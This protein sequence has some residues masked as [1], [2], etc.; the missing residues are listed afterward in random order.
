MQ[1]FTDLEF[2]GI[3]FVYGYCNDIPKAAVREYRRLFSQR[4]VP[5]YKTF[6]TTNRYLQKLDSFCHC[7]GQGRPIVINTKPEPSYLSMCL[8]FKHFENSIPFFLNIKKFC[9]I[10]KNL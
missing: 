5:G 6:E 8:P 3:H 10:L 2:A 4:R 7:R 9:F 1:N